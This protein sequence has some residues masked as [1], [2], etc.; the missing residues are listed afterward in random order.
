M[1]RLAALADAGSFVPFPPAGVSPHVARTHSTLTS[2][3][4][5]ARV[6]ELR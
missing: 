3:A 2:A 4:L 1:A 6:A 5:L